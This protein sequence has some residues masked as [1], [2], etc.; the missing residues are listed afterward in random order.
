M[1]IDFRKRLLTIEPDGDTTAT[2]VAWLAAHAGQAFQ[3]HGKGGVL[4][5]HALGPKA[6]ASR[7]PLNITSRSPEPLRLIS[8]FAH[9]PFVLDGLDDAS[10]EGFWQG[11][12]SPDEANRRRLAMLHG[13][14][15]KDED[16]YAP[17]SD[18]IVHGDRSVRVG[19]LA[20]DDGRL[21]REVR[22]ARRRAHCAPLDRRPAAG[23]PDR[24]RQQDHPGVIMA[25]IWMRQRERLAKAAAPQPSRS[26][27]ASRTPIGSSA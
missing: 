2:A 6:E 15:P 7:E 9:T 16:Y 13:A 3:L 17:A 22:A 21:R 12:K 20:A 18:V 10:V 25:G 8:N 11:L 24:A 14:K 4:R 26:R 23:P 5:L 27:A 19:S 1:K